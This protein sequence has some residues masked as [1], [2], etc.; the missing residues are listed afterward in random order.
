M[1]FHQPG[2]GEPMRAVVNNEK[3]KKKKFKNFFAN[4]IVKTIVYI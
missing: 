2:T 1:S 4:K 3:L